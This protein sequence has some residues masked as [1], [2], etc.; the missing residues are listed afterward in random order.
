MRR[1]KSLGRSQVCLCWRGLKSQPESKPL[2]V[3]IRIDMILKLQSFHDAYILSLER[4][5]VGF[6][7]NV[8]YQLLFF[9]IY[10]D[11]RE[12]NFVSSGQISNFRIRQMAVTWFCRSLITEQVSQ[13]LVSENT[14]N[15]ILNTYKKDTFHTSFGLQK[16]NISHIILIN[17]RGSL[18][19]IS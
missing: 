17:L 15:E 10:Q 9:G 8:G 11:M 18:S 12:W 7:N 19:K 6:S 3:L 16:N 2:Y 14:K 13:R 5:G 1:S 4:C